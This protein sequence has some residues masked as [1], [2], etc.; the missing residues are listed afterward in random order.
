[1]PLV[2]GII[3]EIYIRTRPTGEL[4]QINKMTKKYYIYLL[5]FLGLLTAFGPLV[6]D[7]CLPTLPAMATLFNTTA[8]MVQMGLTTSMLGLA[9]GQV[10][11]GLLSDKYGRKY[12]LIAALIL[13]AISTVG[14]IFS[15][16]IQMLNFCRFLQGFGA[17]GG[18]VLSRSISTDC[19]NGRE[20]AKALV[21]ISAVN[22]IAPVSAPVIGGLVAKSVGWKGIFWILFGIGIVL[23]L[24]C[25]EFSESLPK[26]KRY[27]G[28]VS[29]LMGVF[30]KL[31][32]IKSYVIYVLIY[33]FANGVLFAYISSASFLIQNHF[34]FSELTFSLI[35]GVNAL[36]IGLGSVLT[37]KFK[38]MTDA[39]LFGAIGCSVLTV[40]QLICLFI[41]G[42]NFY[43]FE[44]LVLLTLAS[45]GFLLTS[46]TTLAME[47][48]REHVGAASALFGAV[49]FLSGGIVSPLV[50][51]GDIMLPTFITMALSAIAALCFGLVSRA[52]N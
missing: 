51:L 3:L 42:G 32:K 16:T 10:L 22:G 25:F 30:P 40:V 46:S 23:L 26:E 27:K 12:T 41:F 28:S 47:A 38:K 4:N 9:V 8:S 34:G 52:K 29:S 7:M 20:L 33:G 24:M 44:S 49:G 6:T 48:G 15:P 37:L 14:S 19:F 11:F 36:G 35:F 18:I 21:I 39:M 50:G 1:M 17:A 45:L 13:F 5:A 2:G 43:I 31:L